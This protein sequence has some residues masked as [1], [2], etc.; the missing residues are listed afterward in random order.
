MRTENIRP[1]AVFS[2]NMV[3][4]REQCVRIFGECSESCTNITVSIPELENS[5][6]AVISGGNG[7]RFSLLCK[8]AAVFQWI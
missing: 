2:D 1:A 5:A 3:L 7:K 6:E 8:P 4:Q